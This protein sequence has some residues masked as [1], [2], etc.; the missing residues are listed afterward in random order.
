VKEKR[1]VRKKVRRTELTLRNNAREAERRGR[2][3]AKRLVDARVEVRQA[4]HLLPVR[5]ELVLRPELLVELRLQFRLFL[6]VRREV[7][8]DCARRAVRS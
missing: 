5:D 1:R 2:V 6:R 4:L 8:D 3:E 7:V